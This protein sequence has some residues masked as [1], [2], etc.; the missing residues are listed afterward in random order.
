MIHKGSVIEDV[1]NNIKQCNPYYTITIYGVLNE[2]HDYE[3]FEL[4]PFLRYDTIN[5][6]INKYYNF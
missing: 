3:E 4:F 1:I 6:G 5:N 2:Y